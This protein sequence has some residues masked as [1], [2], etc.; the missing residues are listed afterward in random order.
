[1]VLINY[2]GKE[3][4]DF[5]NNKNAEGIN[6]ILRYDK[7]HLLYYEAEIPL[8]RIFP[9]YQEFLDDTTK[10]FSFGFESGKMEMPAMDVH[11]ASGRGGMKGVGM[12]PRGR[13]GQ[14]GGGQKMDSEQMENIQTM[15]EPSIVWIKK[16]RLEYQSN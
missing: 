12:S 16:A 4:N 8:T 13:G 11:G 3:R 14:R 7:D 15:A 6:A 2:F 9:N 5:I 10:T 1:M